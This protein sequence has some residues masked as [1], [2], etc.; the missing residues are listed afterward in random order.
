M[1]KAVEVCW[2]YNRFQH[3]RRNLQRLALKSHMAAKCQPCVEEFL[4]MSDNRSMTKDLTAK[5]ILHGEECVIQSYDLVKEWGTPFKE[6]E[7]LIHL[8]SGVP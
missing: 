8:S 2:Q 5:R 4:R 3:I 1:N 7:K 6:N